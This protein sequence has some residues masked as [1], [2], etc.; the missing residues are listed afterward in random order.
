MKLT[1][2]QLDII[3]KRIYE[4]V[5]KSITDKNKELLSKFKIPN[6]QYFKDKDACDKI[7]LM[8]EDLEEKRSKLI[9]KYK[10]KTINGYTFL[11]W[12]SDVFLER[13]KTDYIKHLASKE[14]N[15]KEVPSKREIEEEIILSSNKDIPTLIE[16]LTNKYLED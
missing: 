12:T 10:S 9:N 5:S 8:I 13:I 15:F 7:D 11:S 2:K 3:V 1:N 6:H 16:A 4:T 14:Y